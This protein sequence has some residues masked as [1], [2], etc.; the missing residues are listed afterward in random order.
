LLFG[1]APVSTLISSKN[2][3]NVFGLDLRAS[4]V[5]SLLPL[6]TVAFLF[7][8]NDQG[9]QENQAQG[10]ELDKFHIHQK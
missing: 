1:S 7:L 2:F 8:W 6:E 9:I 3:D 4:V 10:I 5:D